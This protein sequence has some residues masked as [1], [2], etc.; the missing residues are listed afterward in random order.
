TCTN[1]EDVS[2]ALIIFLVASLQRVFYLYRGARRRGLLLLRPP[3][4]L[5]AT[6]RVLL[7]ADLRMSRESFLPFFGC[8][9]RGD[10]SMLIQQLLYARERPALRHGFSP[11]LRAATVQQDA[12]GCVIW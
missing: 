3:L 7:F 6:N 11:I 4:C 1:D 9:T 8:K 2:E 5:P 10:C 12:A